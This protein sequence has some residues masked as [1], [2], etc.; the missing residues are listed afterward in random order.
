MLGRAARRIRY[1]SHEQDRI[2]FLVEYVEQER[3]VSLE[4][5][6]LAVVTEFVD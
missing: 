3:S 2:R 6:R 5:D 4:H 1:L